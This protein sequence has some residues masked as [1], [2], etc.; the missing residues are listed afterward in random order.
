MRKFY[1]IKLVAAFICMF[2][3]VSG[4]AFAQ[5]LASVLP[6][7]N[8]LPEDHDPWNISVP[9]TDAIMR[10][11]AQ[12]MGAQKAPAKAEIAE[13]EEFIF[14]GQSFYAGYSFSYDE[15]DVINRTARLTIDGEKVTFHAFFNY[16]AQSA[17]WNVCTDEDF[18]GVY[19]AE[20]K[21][22][23]VKASNEPGEETIVAHTYGG[24][25]DIVMLGGTATPMGGFTPDE[26]IVFD[27]V[28]D[29]EQIKARNH[30]MLFSYANGYMMGATAGFRSFTLYKPN[31]DVA[32]VVSLT[33]K[34]AFEKCYAGNTITKS[35]S[36]FNIGGKD[37]DVTVNIA[38][39]EAFD[40]YPKFFTISGSGSATFT[41]E[42]TPTTEGVFETTATL[43]SEGSDDI[44][45]N[46]EGNG[47]LP[48]DFSPIVKAGEME[49]STSLD[50]EFEL[51]EVD[52]HTVARSGGAG[53]RRAQSDLFVKFDVPAS[54][55]GTLK[56]KGEFTSE[57]PYNI[58]GVIYNGQI[59]MQMYGQFTR[60]FGSEV[61]DL[62]PGTHEIDFQYFNDNFEGSI[63]VYDLEIV[64]E[65]LPSDKVSCKREAV[66][67]GHHLQADNDE[68]TSNIPLYN[69]GEN[70][71][72]VSSISCDNEHF[73]FE[74]PAFGV[75]TF[76]YLEIPV[77]L[78]TNECG[79]YE[80][81][82]TIETSAGVIAIPLKAGVY[83]PDYSKIVKEGSA[84][85]E[86]GHY[87][88]F[89][90]SYG[91]PF[92]V[93]E[94]AEVP[95][96]YNASAKDIDYE[97]L[98][99]CLEAMFEVPE[100]YTGHL[101]WEGQI[102]C[103]EA[104]DIADWANYDYPQINVSLNYNP[105]WGSYWNNSSFFLAGALNGDAGSAQYDQLDDDHEYYYNNTFRMGEGKHEV[106]FC[107]IQLG[108]A[109]YAGEDCVK[110]YN[111]CLELIPNTGI[112]NVEDTK[113]V[114]SRE[115]YNLSGVRVNKPVGIVIEKVKYNDGSVASQKIMK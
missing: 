35:F 50:F 49:I 15:G 43:T 91:S 16:G 14:L 58:G 22:I 89:Y 84:P 38:N 63:Y 37:A 101:S 44:V 93:N 8:T 42:F 69:E 32:S 28:G 48:T 86:F 45:V 115:Y 52:G 90:Y 78:N 94:D 110:I 100:G 56:W 2:T 79:V 3:M 77:S 4:S 72:T 112:G 83:N 97:P 76:E 81:V 40:V 55:K 114:V 107:F 5:Q 7:Q 1:S 29:F 82:A 12:P 109:Y 85:F 95:Y 51:D 105:E 62:A 75:G 31:P 10:N 80:G 41:V 23:T 68:I 27:V 108:D 61:T 20:A 64:L 34:V 99:S 66:S 60:D 87:N 33:E 102:S 88:N 70:D 111:L 39:T 71:L 67:L 104:E 6:N 59:L 21:T 92:I 73:V 19:D 113:Q 47:F 24:Y 26:E 17:E 106:A 54:K 9:V 74:K 36:V 57:Y 98:T 18:E 11:M 13:G 103:A 53:Y 46:L 96:A 25:Y 30:V 65:D